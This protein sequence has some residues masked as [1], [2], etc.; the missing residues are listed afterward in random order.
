MVGADENAGVTSWAR[1][2]ARPSASAGPA[3]TSC[4]APPATRSHPRTIPA[5]RPA[6]GRGGG[7][8]P[9]AVRRGN[10]WRGPERNPCSVVRRVRLQAHRWGRVP[11]ARPDPFPARRRSCSRGSLARTVADTALVLTAS[12]GPDQR[13]PFTPARGRRLPRAHARAPS[14][15]AGR[16]EPRPRRLPGRSA[17]GGGGRGGGEAVRVP[18]RGS[19]GDSSGSSAA[20]RAGGDCGAASSPLNVGAM[21]GSRQPGSTCCRPPAT[22]PRQ[23]L[24]WLDEARP[25]RC[26]VPRAS[27]PRGPR[28]T[29]PPWRVRGPRPPGH[30]DLAGACR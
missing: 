19:T 1:Q 4:S 22:T 11:V 6:V 7:G 29:M 2:T 20:S 24:R 21:E 10:R 26:A 30:P 15:P 12:V 5:A 25:S 28:C 17:G 8:R 13:D 9:G 16:L 14:G 3:T 23:L 27:R 18:G